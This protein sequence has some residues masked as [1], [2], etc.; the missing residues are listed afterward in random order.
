MPALHAEPYAAGPLTR[1]LETKAMHPFGVAPAPISREAADAAAMAALRELAEEVSNARAEGRFVQALPLDQVDE[2][3]L[4][5][6]RVTVDAEAL[7]SLTESLRAHGQ[8]MAIE[9][10]DHGAGTAPRYGLISGWRRLSALRALHTETGEARFAT[11][12][13][14]LR[15]PETAGDAYVAMVEENEIRTGL[16]YYERARIAAKAVEAG[17]FASSKLA[18]QRL[19]ANASRARRSKIGSFL[20]LYSALGDTL[21]FPEAIPERL[22]LALAMRLEAEPDFAA[23]LAQGL[24]KADP[25]DA[26][27][28]MMALNQVLKPVPK[29]QVASPAITQENSHKPGDSVTFSFRKGE[30]R[31]TGPGVDAGLRDRLEIWLKG[32]GF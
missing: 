2:G 16:S 11:V 17:V 26:A 3:W 30:I 5:R 9:V 19:Y 20:S 28:E 29:G 7:S 18:L 4:V 14:V 25:A 10:V 24:V 22:G 12:L 21:R 8:R 32:Q 1:A 23:N 15:R 31:L 27:A 6:D 13:A